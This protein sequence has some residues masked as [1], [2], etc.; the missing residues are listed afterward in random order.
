MNKYQNINNE[1]VERKKINGNPK[2]LFKCSKK[3]DYCIIPSISY[4]LFSTVSSI[5]SKNDSNNFSL[6]HDDQEILLN[7]NI[8]FYGKK[9]KNKKNKRDHRKKNENMFLGKKTEKTKNVFDTIKFPETK[10]LFINNNINN[11]SKNNNN[12]NSNVILNNLE[13]NE[14]IL[15]VQ[16]SNSLESSFSNQKTKESNTQKKT[17]IFKT[18]NYN[19]LG[20]DLEKKKINEGRWSKEEQIKF[21]KA[22]VHFGKDYVLSQKF[23]A[24]RNSVQIRSHAQKFFLKLKTLK[25]NDYDFS[26]DEIKSL[27]DIFNVIE[28]NNKTQINNKEY[29]INTLIAFIQKNEKKNFSI[30]KKNKRKKKLNKYKGNIRIII[31][32][33]EEE[34]NTINDSSL[35]KESQMTIELKL[36]KNNDN[37]A[38]E[39]NVFQMENTNYYSMP[40]SDILLNEEENINNKELDNEEELFILNNTAPVQNE[41]NM[42]IKLE[43]KIDNFK[44]YYDIDDLTNPI[45]KHDDYCFL[46]NNYDLF[47]SD[48]NLSM[49]KDYLF[50]KNRKSQYLRFISGL[51][52]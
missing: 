4:P 1:N 14:N 10:P 24:S 21:I 25:N 20:D 5:E 18:I 48:A 47:C 3:D 37:N 28:A 22:Y 31:K 26:N 33:G 52:C 41:E 44:S 27:S 50:V 40:Y 34:E 36:Q 42:N 43:P 15:K 39:N 30:K 35:N 2:N 38:D 19:L 51:F 12:S 49:E 11:L 16:N 23:I 13:K 46:S 7:K 6:N 29:I 32:K 8:N 9:C 45:N 17:N